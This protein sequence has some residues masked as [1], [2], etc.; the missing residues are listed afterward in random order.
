[1]KLADRKG[2]VKECSTG[3]DRFLEW[4]YSHEVGRIIKRADPA[5]DFPPGRKIFGFWIFT[6]PDPV[7]YPKTWDCDVSI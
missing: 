6:P 4:L 7:V 2:T 1:M 3:Q 5:K